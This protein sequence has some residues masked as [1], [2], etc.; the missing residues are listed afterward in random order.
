MK[1]YIEG[2]YKAR[3][4]FFL[5]FLLWA[6]LVL[7]LQRFD[8]WFPIS[9]TLQE[10]LV[11]SSDRALL[12]AIVST[13]FYL[14]LSGLVVFEAIWTV[15]TRQYPPLGHLVPFRTPIREIKYPILVWVWPVPF[16]RCALAILHFK[17]M[18]GS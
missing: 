11:Q 2:S 14:A 8:T 13:V 9:G 15:R 1:R 12:A 7:F 18:R 4:V 6:G 16:L 3:L 5:A 10:Q 17:C